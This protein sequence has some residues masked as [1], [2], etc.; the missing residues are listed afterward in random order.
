MLQFYGGNRSYMFEIPKFHG[1]YV[2]LN[3]YS[4]N[5]WENNDFLFVSINIWNLNNKIVD[6][7]ASQ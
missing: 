6:K 2:N 5:I 3:D 4:L 1:R 7:I